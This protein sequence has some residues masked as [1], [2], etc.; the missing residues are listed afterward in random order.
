[1]NN[2]L[3]PCFTFRTS[4]QDLA[5][6]ANSKYNNLNIV[7]LD[8]QSFQ[9]SVEESISGEL[10][11]VFFTCEYGD[12]TDFMVDSGV[13]KELLALFFLSMERCGW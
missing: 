1:M 5:I 11:L 4:T 6:E 3:V 8:G 12:W 2:V 10:T 13:K 7:Y 9:D